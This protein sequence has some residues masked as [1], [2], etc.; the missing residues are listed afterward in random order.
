[1]PRV[2]SHLWGPT[3]QS[4]SSSRGFHS[5]KS[6]LKGWTQHDGDWD[7]QLAKKWFIGQT[8]YRTRWGVE[9]H[10]IGW[11]P[12]RH[13]GVQGPG[14]QQGVSWGTG[15]WEQHLR[16]FKER[17]SAHRNG[18]DVHLGDKRRVHCPW[19]FFGLVG[20]SSKEH[21]FILPI[22]TECPL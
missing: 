21:S 3:C 15:T 12:A 1:M 5:Q 4:E 19:L 8:Y 13:Q 16:I 17:A 9:S 20:S 11:V 2:C 10:S 14:R 18:T 7:V 22:F 6:E